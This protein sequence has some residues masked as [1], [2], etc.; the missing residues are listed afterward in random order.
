MPKLRHTSKRR[1][2]AVEAFIRTEGLGHKEGRGGWG[3][4]AIV[5]GGRGMVSGG[6]GRGKEGETKEK[7]ITFGRC[8]NV[9]TWYVRSSNFTTLRYQRWYVTHMS[10]YRLPPTKHYQLRWYPLPITTHYQVP[11]TTKYYPLLSTTAGARTN[12]N[13]VYSS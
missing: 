9:G 10:Y 2:F 11:P 3:R 13:S 7:R 8:T 12:T 1:T 4:G 5:M 6:M